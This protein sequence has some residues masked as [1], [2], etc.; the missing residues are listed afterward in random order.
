MK[1]VTIYTIA[2]ELNMTPSMVSRALS[3]SGKVDEKKRELV[4]KTAEKYNFK[5]NRLASR[6]SGKHIKIGILIVSTFKQGLDKM[7]RGFE[8]AYGECMDYKI[9]Y[10]VSVIDSSLKKAWE[11]EAEL[12]ELAECDGVIIAGFGSEKCTDMLQRFTEINKNLVQLQSI[13]EAVECLFVSRHNERVASALAANFLSCCL[14]KGEKRVLLFTGNRAN[15]L[16]RSAE[17]SFIGACGEYGLELLGTVD[18]KDSDELLE[19]VLHKIFKNDGEKIDGIYITSGKSLPL[20][21]FLKEKG[22]RTALV[23]F[24]TYDELNEYIKD[25]TI[26]MTISQSTTEQARVAFKTL[27]EYLVDGRLP[28]KTVFTAVRPIFKSI[29]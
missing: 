2:K 21:R 7:I 27:V 24:D 12:F 3:P 18:M 29:L 25:G 8:K 5:P 19:E 26:S 16:H 28:E 4:L 20:C 9:T 17:E 1:G 10:T 22:Y 15:F 14:G 13:N 11:C 23:S 6:L